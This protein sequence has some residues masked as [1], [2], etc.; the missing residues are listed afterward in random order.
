VTNAGLKTIAAHDLVWLVLSETEVTALGVP[1]LIKLKNLAW[2]DVGDTRV[3]PIG[4]AALRRALP[5]CQVID[6]H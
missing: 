4:A 6:R 3:G 5:R 2:L 1:D